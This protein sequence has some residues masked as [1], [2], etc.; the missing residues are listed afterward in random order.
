MI[1][2]NQTQPHLMTTAERLEE[3]ADIL[4]TAIIR[5]QKRAEISPDRE[6]F[7]GLHCEPKH[8]CNKPE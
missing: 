4:T 8:A 2:Q 3:I 7:T 6:S 5:T 1:D